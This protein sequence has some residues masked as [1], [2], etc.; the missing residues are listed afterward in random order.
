[1][2]PVGVISDIFIAIRRRIPKLNKPFSYRHPSRFSIHILLVYVICLVIG[3]S[4]VT[5]TIGPFN[6]TRNMAA[7]VNPEAIRDTW[8]TIAPG[9]I[10]GIVL[11]AISI[12]GLGV[13][14]LLRGR[15]FCSRYC[16]V[17]TAMG[18]VQEYARLHI[19]FDPDRCT[20]CGLCE[21]RCPT[22]SI[23]VVSRYVDEHRC[24]RCFDCVAVC[25]ENAIR[26]QLNRN[27]PASALMRKASSK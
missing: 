9:I 19:E 15:E 1:M 16:P 24:V 2:C 14:S 12:V 20:S 10:T 21:D 27:R 6:M 25:P 5:F 22:Q 17:G 11:G 18:Y 23:K 8:G 4:V 3:V 26:Y 13:S 7:V